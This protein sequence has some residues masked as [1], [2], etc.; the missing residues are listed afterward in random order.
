MLNDLELV[1]RIRRVFAA[2]RRFAIV[3]W[4]RCALY[5]TYKSNVSAYKYLTA[6]SR[7]I[8][9]ETISEISAN[10]L[11]A[12]YKEIEDKMTMTGRKR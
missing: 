2:I 11:R 4:H 1:G 8:V 6:G 7:N 3:G 12:R 10:L 5:T 9:L